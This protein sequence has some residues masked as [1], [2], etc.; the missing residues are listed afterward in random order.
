MKQKLIVT[1]AECGGSNIAAD[2]SG[3]IDANEYHN[4]PEGPLV[5]H[6]SITE[7]GYYC[8]DCGEDAEVVIAE[9]KEDEN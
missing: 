2:F 5:V 9:V 7:I 4:M 3:T 6:D 8:Y 1:C